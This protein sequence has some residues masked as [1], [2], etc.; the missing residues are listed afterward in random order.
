MRKFKWLSVLLALMLLVGLL[1]GCGGGD[2]EEPSGDNE[3]QAG[4][5]ANEAP[6]EP[7]KIGGIFDIT[8]GT[9][10]VGAPYA[11][12]AKA[13]VDY[14]NQNGG[15]NGR[16]IDLIDIDY[17]YEIPQAISAY[18]KLVQQDKVVAILGWGTG[19]TEAM[20]EFISSD[21]IPYISGSFSENL[22]EID[23]HPYNFLIAATY[24]EQ[25]RII[26]QYI[27]DNWTEDRAPKVALL[28][29]DTGFGR[30]PIEDAKNYAAEIGVEIVDEEIVD[31]S[32]L[33][34]TS[35]LLNMK[36]KSADFGIIQETSN[37]TATI[38][39][40]AKKLNL[41]TKFFGLNWTADEISLGM[42]GEAA[43]G[44]IG[45]NLFPF[46][47]EDISQLTPF[48]EYFQGKGKSK[49]KLNSKHVQGWAAAQIMLEA[50]KRAGDNVTGAAIKEQL[51]KMK[52]YS[53]GLNAPLGFTPSDHGTYEA[54][55]I[56]V[57]NG[58]WEK[59]TDWFATK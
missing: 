57:K 3:Q 17:S 46:P 42:A 21:E 4:E 39:K 11:E 26:L 40:D 15:I 49:E 10:D 25:A 44:Y 56:Q 52:G 22:L 29:N 37:A 53:E 59:M 41:D 34:A 33:D 58:K 9:G 20:V 13:Y 48:L 24:S 1:A 14:V 45:T 12:G 2:A 5:E 6:K 30:S 32:A 16:T 31:L 18:K 50:I 38:L 8:G 43:E 51:E 19:D 7:I 54:R 23:T 35:Q 55:L 47:Y 27:K 36:S 28:Y